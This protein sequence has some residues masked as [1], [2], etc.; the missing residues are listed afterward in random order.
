MKQMTLNL[1][2]LAQLQKVAHALS[3]E[4]RLRILA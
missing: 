1:T 3:N 2:E 4:L